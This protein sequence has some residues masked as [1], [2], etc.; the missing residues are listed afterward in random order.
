MYEVAGAFHHHFTSPFS[1]TIIHHFFCVIGV[2]LR[3][4][5]AE[6]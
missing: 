1:I 2:Y 3:L 5:A 6:P 4:S